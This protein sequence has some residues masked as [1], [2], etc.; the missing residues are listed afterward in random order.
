M[1]RALGMFFASVPRGDSKDHR[2]V[3]GYYKHM[4]LFG[5]YTLTRDIP[6]GTA[7]CAARALLALAG[8]AKEPGR[9]G[10]TLFQYSCVSG[11]DN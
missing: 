7:V 10:D 6:D 1:D 8:A 2:V 5:F 4:K 3:E 9:I 11:R